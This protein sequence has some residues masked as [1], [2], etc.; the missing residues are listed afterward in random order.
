V[1]PPGRR[2]IALR[3]V[4]TLLGRAHFWIIVLLFLLCILLH[5]PEQLLF[6]R[7]AA[8]GSL[9]GLQRHALERILF[10]AP[11]VY[12]A[13]VFGFT[14][15]WV[16]LGFALAAMLPRVILVSPQ[17]RDAAFETALTALIGGLINSW[18]ASRRREIGRREQTIL[19][20]E[21]VRRELQ[22]ISRRFQEVFEKAHDAIWIQDMEGRIVS[23][24]AACCRVTGYEQQAMNGMEMARLLPPEALDRAREVRRMLLEHEEL[25]QPYE[26][27]IIKQDG[28]RADIMV[29]TS[30]L[31]EEKSTAFLHI[32]RDIS[33]E[34]KLQRSLRLYSE[35]ISRAHEE[36][37]KRIA[38]EL[39]DDTIQ[40]LVAL[41]RWLDSVISGQKKA[42]ARS[43]E[44]LEDVREE[45]DESLVRMRRF[46]QYLRPPILEYLGLVPAL[47][48]LVEQAGREG[49]MRIEMRSDRDSYALSAEQ[50]LLVFRIV[51]EALRNVWKHS[52]ADRC[53]VSLLREEELL[54]VVIED[55]GI[56]FPSRDT[57]DLVSSGKL[58]LMGMQ[59]RSHLL[60]G[61][62]DIRSSPGRGTAVTLCLAA[63]SGAEP[64]ASRGR[65]TLP[66]AERPPEAAQRRR[67]INPKP[68][69]SP[70]RPVCPP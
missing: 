57:N 4:L 31:G 67:R 26:Q 63:G 10:L 11:V 15:G 19:K 3:K 59:E 32:A 30:V 39:H 64:G 28:S 5:Y 69:D 56:G 22:R 12:A 7:H 42:K 27:Q 2:L 50:Q 1:D 49:E 23:A 29:T 20:L 68:G 60:G 35:Q 25:Q 70:D 9:L 52:C 45:I 43:L 36:E 66:G 8:G 54:R 37:R 14:G 21:A 46:I 44:S 34:R 6:F 13:N 48:E 47:R 55:N 58:G 61:S 38:R 51:Q 53:T 18:L 62:L 24:N 17:P 33:E 40:T 16:S 65:G 41:S